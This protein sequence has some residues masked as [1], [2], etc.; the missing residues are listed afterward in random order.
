MA[1]HKVF[2]QPVVRSISSIAE[3]KI[4]DFQRRT[5]FSPLTTENCTI[6]FCAVS[7]MKDAASQT[8]TH[9]GD[10]LVFTLEGSNANHS[11]GKRFN[12]RR[13]QAIAIPPNTGHTTVVT[14]GL[15]KGLSFYCDDC[16][17]LDENPP[18]TR[19]DIVTKSLAATSNHLKHLQ[20]K[21]IFSPA[22]QESSF[23]ELSFLFSNSPI[24][25]AHFS[26]AGETVYYLISGAVS[27]RWQQHGWIELRSGMAAAIPAGFAY[28][29]KSEYSGG[30]RIIA[31][32]CS[33]CSVLR[34]HTG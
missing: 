7:G 24:P 13:Y 28:Q 19:T 14:A 10:E 30:C 3:E 27:L 16:P 20:E 11:G 8:H 31:A 17:H 25:A 33:S 22:S 9:P 4:Y 2:N 6:R 5:V 34:L 18:E 32:S 29:L 23:M 12:L 15:W 1:K 26:H 21:S